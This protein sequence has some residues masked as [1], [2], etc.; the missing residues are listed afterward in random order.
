M[1]EKA[2]EFIERNSKPDTTPELVST[3]KTYGY[4][5]ENPILVGSE[6]DRGGPRAERDYL[7]SLLDQDGKAITYRRLGSDGVGPHGNV[8]DIYLV[9]TSDGET[10]KLWIDMYH[11]DKKPDEQPAPV[12]FQKKISR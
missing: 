5:R 3:D 8:L 10:T 1:A 4:S 6:S 2:K 11:K 12:D 9:T 7:D